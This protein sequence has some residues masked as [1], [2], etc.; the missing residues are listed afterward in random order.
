MV[1]LLSLLIACPAPKENPDDTGSPSVAMPGATLKGSVDRETS[2]STAHLA[3]LGDMNASFSLD[4][5]RQ[6]YQGGDGNFVL[7]PWSLQVVMAQVYAGAEGEAKT[8]IADTF[9]W[10]L[11]DSDLH[12]AFD[13]ADLL[14]QGHDSASSDPPVTLTSTNQIFVTDGYEI[15]ED[16]LNTLSGYYGTGVQQLDFG[17]DPAGVASDI[18]A[19]IADRTGDH[20][21]DLI[22]EPMVAGSRLLL[23][24]ALYFKASWQ[25]PF[26]EVSTTDEP[27]TLLDG[28]EV[29][30]PTMKGSIAL[31]AAEGDGY[32]VADLAYTDPGLSLTIVLPDEGQFEDVLSALTWGDLSAVIASEVGCSECYAELPRFTVESKPAIK[33]ALEA[34]GMGAA[35]GGAYPGINPDLTLAGVDQ[36]GFVAL[37][38]QGTEA[39]AATVAEFTDT[40]EEPPFEPVL[41][42]RPFLWM[43]RE[44]ETGS[45]LFAG[46]ELDPR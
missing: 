35:F 22:T 28:S 46:V 39:A 23:V 41:V 1:F 2:P 42:N 13:A 17:A 18:N 12:E 16:W 3:G 11:A 4:L 10:S 15:G 20:I 38:E 6:I 5:V 8:A 43:V 7:S 27:F 14:V 30:A 29:S 21:K 33:A 45:V 31:A 32:R 26:S 37:T 19:W 40:A 9:G 25:V 34:M 36:A 44:L 24:N